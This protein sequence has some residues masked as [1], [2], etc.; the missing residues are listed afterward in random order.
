MDLNTI[1]QKPTLVVMDEDQNWELI[2]AEGMS[3]RGV[4]QETMEHNPP[5]L[6][7]KVLLSPKPIDTEMER[8]KHH[9]PK[10]SSCRATGDGAD[11]AIQERARKH[12]LS[13]TFSLRPETPFYYTFLPDPR[14][15]FRHN[16]TPGFSSMPPSTN[17]YPYEPRPHQAQDDAGV[18]AGTSEAGQVKMESELSLWHENGELRRQLEFERAR[19]AQAERVAEELRT[20]A[21]AKEEHLHASMRAVASDSDALGAEISKLRTETQALKAELDDA[22]SHIFSLQPYRQ[23]L[24]PKEIGTV[25]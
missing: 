7:D 4:P 19:A 1:V 23:E 6:P 12:R 2:Q 22:R 14:I 10:T 16:T 17:T 21:R 18:T 11:G 25:R 3:P 24:T 15:F 8:S 5:K 20:Y 13:D 9:E